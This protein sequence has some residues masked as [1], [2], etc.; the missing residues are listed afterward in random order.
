[1]TRIAFLF[2]AAIL[3]ACQP[4]FINGVPN[5]ASPYFTV[6]DGSKLVLRQAVSVPAR[7]QNI[8]FQR[9]QP[10]R[11][12]RV[13][14]YGTYCSLGTVGKRNAPQTINPDE[15]L[16]RKVSQERHFRLGYAPLLPRT[17]VAMLAVVPDIDDS[18]A[19]Y[20]VLVTV[21]HLQ[22]SKQP[23][24]S[25]LVCADWNTPQGVIPIS[26]RK[27]RHTLGDWAELQIARPTF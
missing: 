19:A 24:V 2:V 14:V 13:N 8:Y 3:A 12:N 23:D 17:Q 1:M 21:M 22:S 18:S 16:I 7:D 4:A 9:G 6:P 10:M 25:E 27:I 11:W 15:F 20:E 26:V 5:E